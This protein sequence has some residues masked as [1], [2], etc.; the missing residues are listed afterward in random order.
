MSFKFVFHFNLVCDWIV[1]ANTKV[2]WDSVQYHP[3]FHSPDCL[4]FFFYSYYN[5]FQIHWHN[6]LKYD[7]VMQYANVTQRK[8]NKNRLR[9]T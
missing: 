8:Q 2:C 1:L 5:M 6:V 7:T 9:K 3:I 4:K